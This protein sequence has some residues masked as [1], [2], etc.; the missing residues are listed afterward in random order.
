MDSNGVKKV[1]SGEGG[2]RSESILTSLHADTITK[3]MI[4]ALI[5]VRL[6]KFLHHLFKKL[7]PLLPMYLLSILFS[8]P[9]RHFYYRMKEFFFMQYFSLFNASTIPNKE[10]SR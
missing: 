8:A 7:S 3:V 1:I 4:Y 5:M 6:P 10:S 9:F 2:Y